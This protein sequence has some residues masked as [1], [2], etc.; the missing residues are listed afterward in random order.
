MI[1]TIS[2]ISILFYLLAIFFCFIV[3]FLIGNVGFSVLLMI[4]LIPSLVLTFILLVGAHFLKLKFKHSY[5]IVFLISYFMFIFM[6]T[7]F[8]G[9]SLW[10]TLI[11]IHSDGIFLLLL[12]PIILSGVIVYLI[13][14]LKPR[15]LAGS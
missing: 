5:P 3:S 2:S 10:T 11:N 14:T 9:D 6:C 13:Y 15:N 12:L 8:S 1:R 7:F 4:Y